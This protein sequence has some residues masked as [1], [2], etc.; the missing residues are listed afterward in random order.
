MH[1][2]VIDIYIAASLRCSKNS[3]TIVETVVGK[4]GVTMQ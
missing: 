4:D 1:A 3:M 2:G